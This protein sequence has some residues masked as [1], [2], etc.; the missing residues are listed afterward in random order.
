MLKLR[1]KSDF[2]QH[3][4]IL[5]PL[6]EGKNIDLVIKNT[7]IRYKT[8]DKYSK[9]RGALIEISIEPRDLVK[10]RHVIQI[11]DVN[12]IPVIESS[13]KSL[14][15]LKL[16]SCVMLKK[17]TFESISMIETLTMLSITHN[18]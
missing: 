9:K 7:T 11:T 1:Q 3:R 14:T 16:S 10:T 6:F 15:Y 5:T 8:T 4:C 12:L 18:P 17:K 2:I 13:L